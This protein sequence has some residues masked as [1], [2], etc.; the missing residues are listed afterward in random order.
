MDHHVLLVDDEVEITRVLSYALKRHLQI[1]ATSFNSAEDAL[2][3]MK[4]IGH[5][6]SVV[7][8][9]LRMPG[10][11]GIR[12]IRAL[13]DQGHTMPVIVSSGYITDAERAQGEALGVAVW[14]QKP[15]DLRTLAQHVRAA[16]VPQQGDL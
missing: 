4:G 12:F 16:L 5:D 8:S 11:D 6:I 10:M 9:D 7:V 15:F 1:K 14:L 2:A 13:R 3:A